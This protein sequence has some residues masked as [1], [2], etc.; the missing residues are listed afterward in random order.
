METLDQEIAAI[1]SDVAEIPPGLIRE[2]SSMAELGVDSLDALRIMAA[3]EKKYRIEV[4]EEDMGQVRTV[5]D[6]AQMVAA[7]I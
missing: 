2:T 5:A 3:I 6:I 4:P 7:V 1:I